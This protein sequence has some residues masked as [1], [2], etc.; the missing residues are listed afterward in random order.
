MS[1]LS[2]VIIVIYI[3]PLGVHECEPV[4]HWN[5]EQLEA[6][7]FRRN[8]AVVFDTCMLPSSRLFS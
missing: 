5:R 2:M 7:N 6:E 3:T 1:L 4:P 8:G